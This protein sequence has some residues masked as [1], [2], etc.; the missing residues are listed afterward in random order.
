MEDPVLQN[1][2]DINYDIII[3]DDDSLASAIDPLE[4]KILEIEGVYN[5]NK[6]RKIEEVDAENKG[7]ESKN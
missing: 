5:E 6:G 2:E 3:D 7:V 4:N 1:Y